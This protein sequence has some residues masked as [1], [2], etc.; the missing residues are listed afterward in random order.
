LTKD[1]KKYIIKLRLY[2]H[3]EKVKKSSGN[4]CAIIFCDISYMKIS[5]I[6]RG[7]QTDNTIYSVF[8]VKKFSDKNILNILKSENS[9]YLGDLN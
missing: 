4:F 9:G 8:L 6:S 1:V 5:R 3:R 2:S 7:L